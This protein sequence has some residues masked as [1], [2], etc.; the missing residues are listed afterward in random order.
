MPE[1]TLRNLKPFHITIITYLLSL[2]HQIRCRNIQC[3]NL[4]GTNSMPTMGS[5]ATYAPPQPLRARRAPPARYLCIYI[6]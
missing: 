2:P 1:N 4:P 5:H 6:L 3:Y